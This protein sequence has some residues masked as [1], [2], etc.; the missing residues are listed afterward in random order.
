MLVFIHDE[1]HEGI[2]SE[3]LSEFFFPWVFFGICPKTLL[4]ISQ[5]IVLGTSL[6]IFPKDVIPGDFFIRN[7]RF[8]KKF[9]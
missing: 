9:L 1:I 3:I 7:R 5:E 6:G 8:I 4:E 2:T